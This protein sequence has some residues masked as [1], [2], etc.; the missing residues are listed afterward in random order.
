ISP[1]TASPPG[2][3]I[4]IPGLN[5]LPT[6]YA[7]VD[8]K[9]RAQIP[10]VMPTGTLSFPTYIG[11]DNASATPLAPAI[12]ALKDHAMDYFVFNPFVPRYDTKNTSQVSLYWNRAFHPSNLERLFRLNDTGYESISSELEL[13]LPRNLTGNA[14][15]SNLLTTT[16]GDRNT[17]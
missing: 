4:T 8:W 14:K 13:L 2:V 9:G 7:Q 11:Y 1:A 6:V 3:P 10:P 12:D 15:V 5:V 16:S 17:A